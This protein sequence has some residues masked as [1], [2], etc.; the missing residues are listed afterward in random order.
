MPIRAHSKERHV[1][2]QRIDAPGAADALAEALAVRH[3]GG[4]PLIVDP[5]APISPVIVDTEL[6][7]ETAW[8]TLTSGTTGAPKIVVRSAASW[9]V[10]FGP[11]NTELG[12]KPGDGL[13]TPVHQVSSMA[14]FSAAWAHDSALELVNPCHGDPGLNRAVAAHVTPAWLQHLLELLE[15]GQS[16]TVHTVLV[17]GDRLPPELMSRAQAHGLRVITYAG[18]AELS[19]VAW[20]R[21]DGL[22]AFPGVSTRIINDQLWVAS[23]QT[24][25]DVLGGT[26]QCQTMDG[27]QWVTVGDRAAEH[28]GVLELLGRTDGAIITAGATV[29]PADVEA[30]IDQHPEVRA[31]LVLGLPDNRLGRRVVAWFEGEATIAALRDWVRSRLPKAARPVQWHH[32]EAL[33]RTASGKIRRV[34]PEDS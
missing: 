32:V 11:L 15:T 9:Q 13:W 7:E 25:L 14:L 18:A 5:R 24:A 31:S 30:I 19:F 21:G 23:P 34:A 29:R 20:D 2:L 28:D 22:R 33:A 12:L 4:V 27:R 16:S 1:Q 6:P 10:A 26:L 17:G 8:A 3:A